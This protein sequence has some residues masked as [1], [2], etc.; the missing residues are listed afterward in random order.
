VQGYVTRSSTYDAFEARVNLTAAAA[1]RRARSA[2]A[3]AINLTLKPGSFGYVG[4]E[5][6]CGNFVYTAF[7]A[8]PTPL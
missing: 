8:R 1:T 7:A 2:V 4:Y 5:A 3:R 6:P